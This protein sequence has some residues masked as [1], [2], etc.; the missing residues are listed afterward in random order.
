MIKE[1]KRFCGF[2]PIRR[3]GNKYGG[4]KIVFIRQ[5]LITRRL[6]KFDTKVSQTICVELTI[7]KKRWCTL[8]AYRPPQNNNLKTFFEETNLSLSTI[9]NEYDNNS[10]Y[11]D[12][13]N[14][15]KANTCFKVIKSKFYW[16]YINKPVK[17]FSKIWSN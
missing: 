10:Y 7:S 16:C 15:I 1:L 17:E 3:D 14:L 8:F 2:P 5:G 4:G 13:T 11:S 9:V 6:P 12:S